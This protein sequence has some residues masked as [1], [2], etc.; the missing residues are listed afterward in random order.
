M[1]MRRCRTCRAHLAAQTGTRLSV[2]GGTAVCT[3]RSSVCPTKSTS[4]PA[5]RRGSSRCGKWP[6]LGKISSRL[7]GMARCGC[8]PCRTGIRRSRPP[9]TI[10]V[11]IFAMTGSLSAALDHLAALV[12]HGAQGGEEGAPGAGVTEAGVARHSSSCYREASLA[13]LV[14]RRGAV[15]R[16][17]VLGRLERQGTVDEGVPRHRTHDA[18]D[19][20][21]DRLLEGPHRALGLGP[22]DAVYLEPLGR[23][24]RQVPGLELALNGPDG[25]TAAAVRDFQAAH[26]LLVD[27]VVGNQTWPALI[28]QVANG[29]RGDAVR[30]VQ[31]QFQARNLSG[32]PSKGLQIDGIFGPQT[33]GAVRSFQQAVGIGV[34]GIVGPVTWNSLVNGALAL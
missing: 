8:R 24:T 27:G 28:V 5:D 22:E 20:D 23:V 1:P 6:A 25:V 26:G 13:L 19:A 29:S 2:E 21:A 15:A 9:H 10:M 31:S 34:D 30:A 11:G 3:S 4:R 17:A 32:D 18:V 33:E 16:P 14:D 12:D 7:F